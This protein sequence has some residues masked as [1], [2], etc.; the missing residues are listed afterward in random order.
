MNIGYG[1]TL[2]DIIGRDV[3]VAEI[4]TYTMALGPRKFPPL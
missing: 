4:P 1:M 2:Q 3:N